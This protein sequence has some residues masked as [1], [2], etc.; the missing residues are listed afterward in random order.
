M[1]DHPE[2]PEAY[3]TRTLQAEGHAE[4]KADIVELRRF[5]CQRAH[6]YW[7]IADTAKTSAEHRAMHKHLADGYKDVYHRLGKILGIPWHDE[8][9]SAGWESGRPVDLNTTV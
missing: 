4:L 1:T 7:D 6:E 3:Y 9:F 5:L 2:S 8:R